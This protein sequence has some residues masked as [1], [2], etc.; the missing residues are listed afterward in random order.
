MSIPDYQ[1]LMAPVLRLAA[2]GEIRVPSAAEAIADDLELTFDERNERLASGRQTVLH[3]RTH[4][5][6]FYLSKAGLIHSPR[7]GVFTIT[8]A[9]RAL[10]AKNPS[11]IDVSLL[12]GYP[13]FAEFYR[14]ESVTP[15]GSLKGALAPKVPVEALTTPEE[16]IDAAFATLQA[17][18][19]ED[20]LQR[21][22]QNPPIFFESLIVELLLAMGYGG[23]RRD[24]ATH[25]GG[26]GD[27]GVD[28][29]ISEDRLGLDRVYVQAKRYAIGSAVGR[30]EV[31]AFVGSLV[32]FGSTKG[33]FVTTSTFSAQAREYVRGLVQRV[34]LI[35]GEMLTDLMIEHGVGVRTARTLTFQRVD[36]EFFTDPE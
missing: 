2:G 13:A 16:Q 26:S 19:R 9:G 7:R 11:R 1:S 27:G 17:T 35:D 4:W 30:P 28:G 18:L 23:S 3:N 31:Q 21:V 15:S 20:L 32:G 22:L 5:A 10:L 24:A 12:L 34:I 29:V 33:V 14:R 6:K 8:D 36:E 25:L